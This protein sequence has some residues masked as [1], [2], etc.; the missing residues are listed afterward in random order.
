MITG[1]LLFFIELCF[2]WSEFL[3]SWDNDWAGD[4]PLPIKTA[5]TKQRPCVVIGDGGDDEL[6]GFA[7]D[8]VPARLE[9]TSVP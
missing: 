2:F 5:W 1:N 8:D 4:I 9:I 3:L 7:Q 6:G